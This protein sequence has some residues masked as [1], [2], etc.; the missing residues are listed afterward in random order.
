MAY[1]AEQLLSA[2]APNYASDPEKSLF[3]TVAAS[4]TSSCAFGDNYNIAVALRAAHLMTM[5]DRG[6]NGG[7]AGTISSIKEGDISVSYSNKMG[8]IT[9]DLEQTSFGQQLLELIKTNIPAYS[10]AG[11][12][13]ITCR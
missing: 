5:R 11:L 9:S 1:T 10:V 8:D 6:T 2:L 7:T 12:S 13:N 4:R 3:I